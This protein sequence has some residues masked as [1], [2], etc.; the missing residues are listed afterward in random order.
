MDTTMRSVE[1]LDEGYF[2]LLKDKLKRVEVDGETFWRAES[3]YLLD[4]DELFVYSQQRAAADAVQ[5]ARRMTE[6]RGFGSSTAPGLATADARE[7][8]LVGILRGGRIVRWKPGTVLTYC[9]LR[10]TFPEDDRYEE[11]VAHMTQATAD[12]EGTCGVDFAHVP[13]ADQSDDVRPGGV[14]FPVRHIDAGGAFIAAAFFPHDPPSRRRVLIDPSY[15]TQGTFDRTG[16]MR[17]ELGHV[18]GFR[19]EHIRSGAPPVC[20]DEDLGDTLDLT[21]Y[22]P[23]S[24]M[25]YFCGGVGRPELAITALDRTGSRSVYGPPLDDFTEVSP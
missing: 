7:R 22:D 2:D 19:H 4:E 1:A 15:F 9:V 16:V 23:Q 25:H 3:D 13:A 17:H 20:P 12:W 18:L 14:V 6:Q 5:Q 8:G 11:V 10:T 24:V 21:D